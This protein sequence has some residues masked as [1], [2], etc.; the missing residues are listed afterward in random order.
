MSFLHKIIVTKCL[1]H[2]YAIWTSVSNFLLAQ[3]IF[4]GPAN[5]WPSFQALL[6]QISLLSDILEYHVFMLF[7]QSFLLCLN[8]YFI[9]NIIFKKLS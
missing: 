8:F 3:K 5:G 9:I 2:H 6:L 1:G 4:F 7:V